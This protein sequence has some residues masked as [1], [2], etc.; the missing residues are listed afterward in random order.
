MVTAE[1][2][3][4]EEETMLLGR[5]DDAVDDCSCELE[6]EVK[7]EELLIVEAEAATEAEPDEEAGIEC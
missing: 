3:D 6:V 2:E 7:G 1:E 5:F 4:V